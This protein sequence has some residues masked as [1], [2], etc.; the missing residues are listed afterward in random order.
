MKTS[1]EEYARLHPVD[2]TDKDRRIMDLE[3]KLI[4][5]SIDAPAWVRRWNRD[6]NAP[7]LAEI[8]RLRMEETP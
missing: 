5:D 8:T 7:I 4:V 1:L 2:L 3:S 6:H